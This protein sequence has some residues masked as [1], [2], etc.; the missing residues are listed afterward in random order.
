MW[1]VG[2]RFRYDER[3]IW[4]ITQLPVDGT[5]YYHGVIV[6][7]GDSAMRVGENVR[8]SVDNPEDVYL[9]NF[10]KSDNF[11]SLYEKLSNP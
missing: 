8:W 2:D 6:D 3:V 4:E 5:G 7:K 9:G 10:S 1:R 11:N